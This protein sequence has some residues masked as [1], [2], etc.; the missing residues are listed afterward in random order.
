MSIVLTAGDRQEVARHAR[1]LEVILGA[2]ATGGGLSVLD[3]QVPAGTPGP[4]LHRHPESDETFLVTEGRLLVYVDGKVTG[5]GPGGVAFVSRGVPH[6]FATPPGEAA[7]FITVHTPGGFEEFHTAAAQAEQEAGQPLD[8]PALIALASKFD[9]QLA[10]P[11]L[12]PTG[13]LAG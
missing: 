1:G 6:T 9:W 7:R 4:P 11:P 13:N 10:G 2:E 12:L 5:L 3:C 8:V